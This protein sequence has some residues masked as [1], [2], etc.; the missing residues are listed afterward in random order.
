MRP[1]QRDAFSLQAIQVSAADRITRLTRRARGAGIR[2]VLASSA[3]WRP[4]DKHFSDLRRCHQ[5]R[6]NTQHHHGWVLDP[7]FN[8]DKSATRATSPGLRAVVSALK[9][10]RDEMSI[11]R[12][13]RLTSS[14]S[15]DAGSSFLCSLQEER[16]HAISRLAQARPRR[17]FEHF[18]WIEG[19]LEADGLASGGNLY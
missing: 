2:S 12:R 9:T 18:G 15:R 7:E 8:Y 11:L 17:E 1:R 16:R 5:D 6:H 19:I 13:R 3:S 14:G 10:P 4:P